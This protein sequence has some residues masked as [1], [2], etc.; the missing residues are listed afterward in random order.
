M[1]RV[2]S[3]AGL[4]KVLVDPAP[5]SWAASLARGVRASGAEFV[6]LGETHVLLSP[7][8]G[9]ARLSPITARAQTLS[10]R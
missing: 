10:C 9:P 5:A 8:V 6:A 4:V 1:P 3:R 7:E 2:G